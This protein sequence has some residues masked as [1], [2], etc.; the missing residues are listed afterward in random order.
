MGDINSGGLFGILL[1]GAGTA[2]ELA[3]KVTTNSVACPVLG[4]ALYP[5][6]VVTS[7]VKIAAISAYDYY[8]DKTQPPADIEICYRPSKEQ[9]Q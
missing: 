3:E 8:R 5:F 9:H 2:R 7:A 6:C 1:D 4:L